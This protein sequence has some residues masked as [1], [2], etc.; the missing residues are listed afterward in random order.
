M[1]MKQQAEREARVVRLFENKITPGGL[2]RRL[3]CGVWCQSACMGL[4]EGRIDLLVN[5]LERAGL[6]DW[7][8]ASLGDELGEFLFQQVEARFAEV[9]DACLGGQ[10]DG[11]SVIAGREILILRQIGD[12]LGYVHGAVTGAPAGAF[13]GDGHGSSSS[14]MKLEALADCLAWLKAEAE[15][16]VDNARRA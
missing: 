1:D 15:A 10:F 11:E 9:R 16:S 14:V 7:L 8:K 2:V 4:A 12:V 13:L 6:S 3:Q 5:L